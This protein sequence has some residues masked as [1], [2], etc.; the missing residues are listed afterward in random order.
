MDILKYNVKICNIVTMGVNSL[1]IKNID[2]KG[3]Y[4]GA[5]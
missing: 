2:Q 5:Q 3:I 4:I 1:F